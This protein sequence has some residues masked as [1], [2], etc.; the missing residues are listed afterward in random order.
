MKEVLGVVAVALVLL[1]IRSIYQGTTSAVTQGG[2]TSCLKVLG[3]TTSEQDG[4]T[5]IVGSVRNECGRNY[6]S[7]TVVFKLDASGPE[8]KTFRSPGAYAQAYIRDLKPS[9]MKRFKTALP[10]PKNGL[11][12]FDKITAF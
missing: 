12:H 9:E 1:Y 5:Y 8:A 3:S 10:I 2:D 11:Y 4:G 7:V 6:P